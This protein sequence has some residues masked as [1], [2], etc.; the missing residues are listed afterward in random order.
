MYSSKAA[1]STIP[2]AESAAAILFKAAP[3]AVGASAGE[4]AGV[5]AGSASFLPLPAS[6]F[7]R[8]QMESADLFARPLRL[9][10]SPIYAVRPP[11]SSL[12][13]IEQYHFGSAERE[14]VLFEGS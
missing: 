4:P 5:P 11:F 12:I 2:A 9:A 13:F 6:L 10:P 7:D 1:E 3:L 8:L 14:R